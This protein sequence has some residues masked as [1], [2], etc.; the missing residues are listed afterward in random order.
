CVCHPQ[1][2]TVQFRP[3]FQYTGDLQSIYIY[4][5]EPIGDIEKYN[6][7]ERTNPN[8]LEW[9]RD[10]VGENK[11]VTV[12]EIARGMMTYSANPNTDYLIDALGIENINATAKRITKK[13]HSTINPIGASVVIP[14]YLKDVKDVK[15]TLVIETIKNYTEDQYNRIVNDVN[16][17]LQYDNYD[18]E[19]LQNYFPTIK[20]QEVWSNN[21]PK[22]TAKDYGDILNN[23]DNI[24]SNTDSKELIKKLLSF[25]KTDSYFFYGKSGKTVNIINRAVRV[26]QEFN[27]MTIV[28]LAHNLTEYERIK[29]DN[30]LDSFVQNIVDG[31]YTFKKNS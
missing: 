5:T 28:F 9:K 20:E 17:Y 25:K 19:E 18:K 27:D 14:Y 4:G 15:E 13:N 10:M 16:K 1:Y 6:Y 31:I 26:E 2:P 29:A 23:F 30:N 7:I 21:S 3:S 8:Y 24:L 11:Y 22:S 12:F